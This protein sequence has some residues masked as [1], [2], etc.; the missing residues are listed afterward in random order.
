MT[1]LL[2]LFLL[3]QAATARAPSRPA[4]PPADPRPNVIVIVAD[5]LGYADLGVQGAPD[6]QTPHI[7]RIFRE[8]VRFTDGYMSASL[9]SPSRAGMLT[10]RYQERFGHDYNPGEAGTDSADFALPS[11][12][13]TLAQLLKGRGYATAMV[14]KWHLGSRPDARPLAR[15]FDEFFGFLGKEHA[16]AR[17]QSTQAYDP[18]W[19]GDR[20]VTDTAYLTR[21]FA[22]EAT[23]FIE[24][25]PSAPFFLYVPF[26]AVHVPMQEDPATMARTAGISSVARRQYVSMLASMDDAVGEL[27]ATLDRLKLANNTI[28]IFVSDNGGPTARTTASNAPLRGS[29]GTLFEGGIRVPFGIRWP[30]RVPAGRTYTQPVIALDVAPTVL[31]AA[32]GDLATTPFDGVDLMPFLSGARG[33]APPHERLFWRIGHH[34]AVREGKWKLLSTSVVR[35]AKLY[36]LSVDPGESRPTRAKHPD[37]GDRMEKAYKTWNAGMQRTRGLLP[38]VF[39]MIQQSYRLWRAG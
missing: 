39:G 7:D 11:A 10:G 35:R 25:H 12:M 8:G 9:C 29:K 27:L 15:G 3:L 16:Y 21:A 32:G 22:R 30:A 17:N 24:R 28:V 36:D 31:A 13:P 5:D 19:R 34:F 23:S 2:G 38:G 1:H 26:N 14:G 6:V 20:E 33:S 37:V 18:L 4:A